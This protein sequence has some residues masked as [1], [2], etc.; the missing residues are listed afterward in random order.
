MLTDISC[1]AT[2]KE[3]KRLEKN[4]KK[5]DGKG[6]YLHA[7]ANGS[8]YW[9]Y[10]Y[11]IFGKES[12][13]ALGVFPEVTLAE[14]R[15]KHRDAHKLVA[16]NID[17]LL[18]K[19]E[20]QLTR[21]LEAENTLDKYYLKWY[22]Q[23]ESH[24]SPS[25]AK[26]VKRRFEKYLLPDLGGIGMTDLKPPRLLTTIRKIE[27][28][29]GKVIARKC[30]GHV[31]HIFRFACAEGV[32]V[33]DFTNALYDA[34]QPHKVTHHKSIEAKQLPDLVYALDKNE[35]KLS[36]DTRNLVEMM[37]HTFV[38]TNELIRAEKQHIDL[39]EKE[40]LIPAEWMKMSNPHIVPLSKQV[41]AIIKKQFKTYPNSKYLFPS[42]HGKAKHLS[43]GTINSALDALGYKGVHTGH[44]FRALAKS[45]LMEKLNY[46]EPVAD[47][48]LAHA[49][50]SSNGRAYDRAKFLD[51]R[52]V[53]MQ[54]WS[55]YIDE[56]RVKGLQ[57]A[58]AKNRQ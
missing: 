13:L 50:K 31:G 30:L 11:R 7:Y 9:R 47:V 46:P 56:C 23:Y 40:W 53:M 16:Q 5:F 19:Q 1:K 28:N 6:L 10:K 27:K 48:Q 43:N 2:I 26:T 22:G 45:T 44:G 24:W 14:A 29:N 38:R 58:I 49:P 12:T 20:E 18:V 32:A 4:I 42:N 21:K 41:L 3:A 15:D 52:K 51:Q 33:T 35:P 37:L 36:I 39:D 57:N 25:Y 17:P 55:D 54:E 8:A 34:L